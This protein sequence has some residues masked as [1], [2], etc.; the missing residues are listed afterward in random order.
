M[1]SGADRPFLV[2]VL[3][4][5]YLLIGII[6]LIGGALIVAGGVLSDID[7]STEIGGIGGGAAIILGLI[8]LVIGAGLYKGWRIM[9]YL[10]VLFAIIGLV[11]SIISIVGGGAVSVVTLIIELIILWYLFRRNVKAFFLD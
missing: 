4:V 9:W 1:S 5:L 3:S 11:V 2:T 7:G 6:M 10:G 8:M